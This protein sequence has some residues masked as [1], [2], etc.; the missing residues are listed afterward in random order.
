[1]SLPI[2]D[3]LWCHGWVS[4]VCGWLRFFFVLDVFSWVFF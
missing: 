2:W 4:V 3:M 1:L